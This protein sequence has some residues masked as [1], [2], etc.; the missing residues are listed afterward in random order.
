MLRKS[1]GNLDM[2]EFINLM[3]D[4]GL[5]FFFIGLALVIVHWVGENLK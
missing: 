1:K 5:L 2:N 3:V 4:V